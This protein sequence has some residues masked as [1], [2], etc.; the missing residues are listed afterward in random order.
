M[1]QDGA[2]VSIAGERYTRADLCFSLQ[3]IVFAMLVE[4]TGVQCFVALLS[5]RV[6]C[7]IALLSRRV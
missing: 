6:Q 5:R 1:L 4:I 2:T 7:F 3:E